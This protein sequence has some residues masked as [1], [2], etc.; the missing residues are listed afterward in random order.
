MGLTDCSLANTVGSAC[1]KWLSVAIAKIM[2]ENEEL[3][4]PYPWYSIYLP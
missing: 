2:A 1:R 3:K 4:K